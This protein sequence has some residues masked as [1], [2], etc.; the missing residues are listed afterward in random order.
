MDEILRAR[1]LLSASKVVATTTRLCQ[2]RTFGQVIAIALV[3][4]FTTAGA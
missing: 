2:M 1:Q 3:T 4:S